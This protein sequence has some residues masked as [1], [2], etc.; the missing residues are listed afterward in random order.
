MA[1]RMYGDGE[2]TVWDRVGRPHRDCMCYLGP[3]TTLMPLGMRKSPDVSPRRLSDISP[4][5]RQLKYLVV[6]EAIKE[7]LKSSRSVED[8]NS[9]S[10]EER[11]LRITGYYGYQPWSAS[12]KR[13]DRSRENVVGTTDAQSAGAAGAESGSSRRRLHCCIRVTAVQVRKAL[14]GVAMVMCV[15]SSWAGST[16][17]AKLTFKQFDAPFT[18]TWFA[19]TWNCLFFP[20][21]YIGHLCKSPERQTARQRLREC[22]RFFG[23]D[24]LT[25]KVFF[26][27]VAP[28]G[29]LWILTNYLY[30]Q[31]LRKINTTDVSALFCCNKAFVF[32][33][34][35]IVLRDRFMGVRIVAAIL[36]IAGI[37]MM[38]YADGFHSHSV[39]G[40][41]LV[42][43]SAS[44]SALY[45]VLFKMVLG[46]A[47]FG[48]AALFLSIV[49]STNFVFVSFVP[50][51]LYFTHVEYIESLRDIPWAYLCGVAALL[52][53]FNVLVNFG[54]AITYPTLI[55]LGIVLS[56]PVNA[57][58]DLYTCEIHFNS[59]RLIAVFII[60]LGFLMLLLPEDWDQCII[61][62]SQKLRK[63]DEPAEGSGEAGA[64]TGLNWRGRARTSMSTY[65]L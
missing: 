20:L 33:L 44:M 55:S 39:I 3:P 7:D 9:A 30:L 2:G 29:L 37:V 35:W 43:A 52:F 11:I 25:P 23:D 61:Q 50:V 54:I 31:A 14:W 53:A 21:Y 57:M 46:S 38:T 45:K 5:L 42:V 27:K 16:Q 49:G 15:C 28:F 19:T 63:R 36:A 40:I 18:L 59:V 48:E 41:A 17:L 6:D 1:L 13:E 24:G 51:M 47:K 8:I 32:L 58:V 34:S 10:I 60:C 12:Y 64:G 56:V 22:C 26:T 4:Q 65:A 62:L